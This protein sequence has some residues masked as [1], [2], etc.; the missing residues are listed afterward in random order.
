MSFLSFLG[1]GG[2]PLKEALRKG[3]VIVDVRT[4]HEYDQGRIPGSIN[5]PVDRITASIERI[6]HMNKPVICV[7]ASGQ[8]SGSAAS[9]LKR[10]GLKDIYDGG[11]WQRI[12]RMINN[13]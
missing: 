5:I 7:C 13:L 11:S 8:R 2:G 10:N 6:R 3:A 1:F 12:L 9:I 4:A